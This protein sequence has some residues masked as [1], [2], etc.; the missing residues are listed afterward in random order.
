MIENSTRYK[1]SDGSNKSAALQNMFPNYGG[2]RF[3]SVSHISF[4]RNNYILDRKIV[5]AGLSGVLEKTT[6]VLLVDQ[7]VKT[8]CPY[9]WISTTLSSIAF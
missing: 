2:V 9:P 4:S 6:Y 1:S 5:V 3:V 7:S 8:T